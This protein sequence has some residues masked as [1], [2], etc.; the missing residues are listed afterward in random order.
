[1]ASLTQWTWVWVNSGSWWW[2]GRPGV[3]WF[4]GLQRVGHDWATDLI[5]SDL[6]ASYYRTIYTSWMYT[7]IYF[8]TTFLIEAQ[9]KHTH[10][11]MFECNFKLKRVNYLKINKDVCYVYKQRQDLV[12]ALFLAVCFGFTHTVSFYTKWIHFMN[13]EAKAASNSSCRKVQ[14]IFKKKVRTVISCSL[15]S[16]GV[17]VWTADWP[18]ILSWWGG[19]ERG[20]PFAS[21][22]LPYT[23]HR[24][25]HRPGGRGTADSGWTWVSRL[26]FQV[27]AAVL[28]CGDR[29]HQRLPG[30][31]RTLTLSLF[32]D[33]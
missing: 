14:T 25:L 31:K 16:P 23:W 2:T 32:Q 3:L 7:W 15:L 21:D 11:Q 18:R 10:T 1:M 8:G 33:S 9:L 5:W 13:R 28:P 4:M 26:P 12:S 19:K 20:D 22:P 6:Y 30:F 17:P 24:A 29:H 27:E